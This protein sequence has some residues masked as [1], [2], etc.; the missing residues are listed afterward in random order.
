M[1]AGPTVPAHAPSPRRRTQRVLTLLVV[2]LVAACGGGASPAPTIPAGAVVVHAKDRAFDTKQLDIPADTEFTLA[3][4]NEDGDSHNIEIR[5]KSGFDGDLL[6]RFDP[7]ST[8]THLLTVGKIPK[9]TY[10][11]LCLV[12]PNMS[13]TVYAH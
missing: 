9:G 12:H 5:T 13:G 10:F 2:L 11:F 1:P 7:V 4:V 8:G 6:F 3:F